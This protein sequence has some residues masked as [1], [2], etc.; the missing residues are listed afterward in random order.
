MK[1]LVMKFYAVKGEL[2]DNSILE[3]DYKN[4]HAVGVMRL[5]S[6]NLFFRA[7]L[8]TYALPYTE[9]KKCFRR[10][11]EVPATPAEGAQEV[12]A[13]GTQAAPVEGAGAQEVP[14]AP[15][16]GDQAAL[17]AEPIAPVAP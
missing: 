4:A 13:E 1:V 15:V 12:P 2:P 8:K 16:E 14:A 17:A 3:P 11:Q 7:G 9:I 6:E 5:G 10:V